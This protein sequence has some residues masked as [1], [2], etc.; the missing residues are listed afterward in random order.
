MGAG[1]AMNTEG[2]WPA[3]WPFV[4]QLLH[5]IGVALIAGIAVIGLLMVDMERGTDLRRTC[6]ALHKSLGITALALAAVRMAVRATTQ[7][8]P[9][10]G[11]QRIFAR[12]AALSHAFMYVLLL[13]LPVSGWLL[14]SAAGQPLPWFGVVQLPALV[15]PDKALRQ[16]MD[17][18]HSALFWSLVGLV[19]LH[20]LAVFH[21][22]L[23]CKHALLQR[24]WP[25]RG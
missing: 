7:A 12:V 13:A 1:P 21:H 4:V 14:N 19:A 18:T 9:P 25:G 10:L 15:T 16:L 17:T 23:W 24:M 11:Q 22:H 2:D 8:P 20:L 6:Y 5:W 3:R